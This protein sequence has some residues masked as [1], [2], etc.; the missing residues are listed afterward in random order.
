MKCLDKKQTKYHI[1]NKKS[2]KSFT[3][4]AFVIACMCGAML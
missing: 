3:N 4:Y 2:N 1:Y